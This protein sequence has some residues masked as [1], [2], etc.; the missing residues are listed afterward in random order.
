MTAQ[1][2]EVY[3]KSALVSQSEIGS[4]LASS[5]GYLGCRQPLLRDCRAQQKSANQY[6]THKPTHSNR[7]QD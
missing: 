5:R 3:R 6:S 1:G 2:S 4:L 7:S